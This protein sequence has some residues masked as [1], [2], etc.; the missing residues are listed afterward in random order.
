MDVPKS[1]DVFV[2]GFPEDQGILFIRQNPFEEV[3]ESQ[4]VH[5]PIVFEMIQFFFDSL[6]FL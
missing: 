2:K 1:L 5:F 4:L 6:D 3:F